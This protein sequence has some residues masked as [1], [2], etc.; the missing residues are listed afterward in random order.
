MNE[1]TGLHRLDDPYHLLRIEQY[2]PPRVSA[3]SLTN[4]VRVLPI[5]VGGG[6]ARHLAY[7]SPYTGAI[8]TLGNQS[9]PSRTW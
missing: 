8:V 1:Y 5:R 7:Q 9:Q 6:G 4:R 2:D 3:Y